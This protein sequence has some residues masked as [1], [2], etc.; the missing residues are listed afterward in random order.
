M[1]FNEAI[2]TLTNL[3]GLITYSIQIAAVTALNNQQDVIG[4]RS[5]AIEIT[6]LEGSKQNLLLNIYVSI[7]CH[8]SAYCSPRP[9]LQ[10]SSCQ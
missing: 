4:D 8:Y 3:N 5:I 2:G 10:N 7:T 9:K 6:T 1:D